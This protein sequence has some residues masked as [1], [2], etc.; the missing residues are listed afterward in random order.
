[1]DDFRC[2]AVNSTTSRLLDLDAGV[3]VGGI[4]PSDHQRATA[5]YDTRV[6]VVDDCTLYREC[7]VGVLSGRHSGVTTEVAWD[8]ASLLTELD[9]TPPQ[10]ILLNMATHDSSTLLRQILKIE[11]GARVV[12]IGVSEDDESV[13]VECAEAG[14]VGYH[15]RNESL[16]DLLMLIRRVAAGESSCPASVSGI[17][18]R[19]L[20]ALAAQRRPPSKEVVLT[21]REIEILRMLEAGMANR[22]IAE[23]LCIA[24]HTVKNHVHSVLNKLGVTSREQAAAIARNVCTVQGLRPN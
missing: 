16:D 20:S 2:L 13:I 10:V 6:L 4:F 19:R 15:L 7:L 9:A 17:L 12:V 1:M 23:S 11:P 22:E 8:L 3:A 21:A 24:V 18:L 5:R 14:A